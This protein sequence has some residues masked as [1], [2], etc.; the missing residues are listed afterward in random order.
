MIRRKY[1]VKPALQLKYLLI[2]T[3]AIIVLGFLCYYAFF[4]ALISAPGMEA[5]SAGTVKNFRT[6]YASGFF[7]VIFIFALFILIQS[8]FYFH[9]IIGPM[10]V[11][12]GIMKKL[13][14]GDFSVKVHWRKRDQTKELAAAI[15]NM[16]ENTRENVLKDRQAIKSAVKALNAKDSEK[17]KK[18][19]SKA[20]HWCKTETPG[21]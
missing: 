1:I 19:L 17:A 8:V 10:F 7:W 2:F 4:N 15:K 3:V 12:E 13:A 20:T 6:V 14:K 21:K 9:R 11:F 5:L 16:I 18:L